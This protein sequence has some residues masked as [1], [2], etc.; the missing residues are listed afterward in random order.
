M[1]LRG[2][3]Q[4]SRQCLRD[5]RV[6]PWK[7][8]FL[9]ALCYF[10]SVLVCDTAIYLMNRQMQN[11]SGLSAMVAQGQLEFA[12]FLVNLVLILV[13]VLWNA[14]YSWFALQLSR[15][16]PVSFGSFLQGFRMFSRVILLYLLQGFFIWCWALLFVIPGIIAAYRY[17]LAIYVLLDQPE[18]SVLEAIQVSKRLTY[19]HKMELF[20]MDL[21]FLWYHLP[22]YIALYLPAFLQWGVLPVAVGITGLLMAYW[23]SLLVPFVFNALA[24]PYVVTTEAHAY[25]WMVSLD[26]ARREEAWGSRPEHDMNW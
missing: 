12:A 18:T 24:M 2:L 10:G 4:A 25:N 3:K 14:G 22:V 7:L 20:F 19:G 17:R 15:G 26:R 9:Y 6:S 11:N 8:S 23:I 16:Q 5:S 21:S 13:T 1:N